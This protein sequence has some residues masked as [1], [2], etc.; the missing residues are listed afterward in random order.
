MLI[1]NTIRLVIFILVSIIIISCSENNNPVTPQVNTSKL[2]SF[3]YIKTFSIDDLN[4]IAMLFKVP[5]AA[6][7]SVDV[8]KIVYTT[9]DINS[10]NINVSG[11]I[12]SPVTTNP[13]SLMSV[14]HATATS[15]GEGNMSNCDIY[16]Y[17]G[18]LQSGLGFFTILPDY[19]GYGKTETLNHPYLLYTSS[20]NTVIDMIYA[21]K[22]FAQKKSI[23]INK[24]LF[25]MGYSEGGYVT[26]AAF[27]ELQDKY[28]NELPV[29]AVSCGAGP[30]NLVSTTKYY[31]TFTP[32]DY[33]IFLVFALN[34]Y[35]EAYF[36]R[37]VSYY[38]KN[39]YL[40][41]FNEILS[42]KNMAV[43]ANNLLTPNAKDFIN[44]D[45][46]NN[47]INDKATDFTTVLLQNSLN[48][49]EPNSPVFLYHTKLDKVVPSFN[50]TETYNNFIQNGSKNITFK[51]SE[52]SGLTHETAIFEYVQE[53]LNYF[54]GF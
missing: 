25:L 31:F 15:K 50:S 38:I 2:V 12:F 42:G 13:K 8:Y 10:K 21:S 33:P 39:E 17:Q 6:Q 44:S 16:S 37:S 19:I 7:N 9:I 52:T 46:Y 34:S 22:E 40:T 3:E 26:M 24:K 30:Y 23:N 5:F 54:K 11:L 41:S 1:K 32:L 27:K 53:S 35:N 51:L 43:A 29:T 49:W 14:Q 48:N 47:I 36:Q 20:A 28:S 18:I 45:F 4:S